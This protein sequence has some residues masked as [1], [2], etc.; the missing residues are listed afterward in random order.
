MGTIKSPQI[1]YSF[2]PHTNPLGEVLLL[3]LY[4]R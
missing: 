4:Y 3:F 2:N 1:I